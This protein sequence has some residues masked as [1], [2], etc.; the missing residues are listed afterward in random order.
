[1]C[2]K[3]N[4]SSS[5]QE[6]CPEN[7]YPQRMLCI[8]YSYVKINFALCRELYTEQLS[9]RSQPVVWASKRKSKYSNRMSNTSVKKKNTHKTPNYSHFIVDNKEPISSGRPASG[10]PFIPLA[11]LVPRQQCNP[12]ALISCKPACFQQT[13]ARSSR[14]LPSVIVSQPLQ[15]D[16]QHQAAGNRAG[17]L[18]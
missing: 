11:S 2:A 4:P 13:D 16:S 5:L 17:F 12:P 15:R 3:Q 8:S 7:P 14:I 1:V 18:S 10:L 6:K 9:I